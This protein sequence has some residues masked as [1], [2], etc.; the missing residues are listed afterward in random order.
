MSKWK[1]V[2]FDLDDTLYPERAYV[3]SGFKA[4]AQW[5]EV[6]LNIPATLGFRELCVLFEKGVRN[7]TFNRWLLAHGSVD[8]MLVKQLVSIYRNHTP[9][10]EPFPEIPH[11]LSS[12]RHKH[13]L[14]LISDG[15][16]ETQKKK[17]TALGLSHFFDAIV[18]SD[19]WGRIAW[20]PSKKPF[21][22]LLQRLEIN[23]SDT[24]YI[25]DNPTKDFLG[26]RQVGLST[27]WLRYPDGEYTHLS[28]P[29]DAYAPQ[30]TLTLIAELETLITR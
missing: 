11:L 5:A 8:D 1:A 14:G 20:K 10:I 26:A 30:F 2:V 16:L 3:L 12:L 19:E 6:H 23:A 4:V 13:K 24:V 22:M 15:Y 21:E 7:D 29:S 9:V 17:L 27:I 28:P 18:F 25:A